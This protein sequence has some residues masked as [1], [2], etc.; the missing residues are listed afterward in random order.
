MKKTVIY[1]ILLCLILACYDKNSKTDT[2]RIPEKV[3][4]FLPFK[5][6]ALD[7]TSDFKEIPENWKIVGSVYA[8]QTKEKIL[9]TEEG[10]V[11]LLNQQTEQNKGH[12]F[13]AFE[14]GDMELE[15]DV[16]MPE[17]S[18]S[19]LY[20]QGRYEVQLLD[21]WGVKNPEYLDMGGIYHRWDDARGEGNEGYEGSAPKINAAKAPGLWQHFKIVFHAPKF[22]ASG[23]KI[24]NAI[25]EKVWLNGTLIQENVEVTG[26]TR[27]SVY[28]DEKPIGPLMIQGDH[29]AVA[30]KNIKY[31]LYPNSKVSL[32]D[33]T[34]KEYESDSTVIVN[35][36]NKTVVREISTDSVAATMAS[37]NNPQ[38]ILQYTGMMNIPESGD[39]LF[40]Y[41]INVG[42]GLLIIDK[43]TVINLNGDHRLGDLG[44]GV[45]KLNT[46][47]VP[48][49]LIYNKHLFWRQGFSLEV[50]GP[51]VQKHALHAPSSL[52][53][54][55]LGGF[56]PEDII[57]VNVADEAVLQRSFLLFN[58]VKRTHCISVGTPQGIHFSYDLTNGA[59]LKVWD[60]AFFDA[61]EMWLSRGEKQ[62]GVPAGFT[63]SFHGDPEFV[64]LAKPDA[65]W[66]DFTTE[67]TDYKFN[68]YNLDDV[69]L[70]TFRYQK[71]NT[72]IAD[73][74]TPAI[75]GRSFNRSISFKGAT[76][77]AHK[78]AAGHQIKKL[79]NGSYIINDESYFINFSD[80][81]SLK[82]EIRKSNG[83]NEL[84]VRIPEGE[85][86]LN[87]KITW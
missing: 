86:K 34:L 30:L 52:D 65:E 74:M 59:V 60:G 28:D 19:G 4:T 22:D 49:Q 46:G 54:T 15:I 76:P 73:K 50:E 13:T 58:G 27:A 62:L 9:I 57:M 78:I 83:N 29:G 14:H 32:T 81:L 79:P 72:N 68:G 42:G 36:A 7:G 87:Y 43:D 64:T 82:P 71:G 66:P 26:P 75:G 37:G 6:I 44:V 12:L 48:F 23:N 21:S 53:H 2:A 3:L 40:D 61:T 31:K 25:F 69:G 20:F 39:Y 55:G 10:T 80:D 1:I 33:I 47:K 85:H 63:V 77:V 17:G 70:P 56:K 67:F 51:G 11:V 38:K 41:R 16:M 45:K 24:K 35:L 18:N 8:D 84:I 5:T